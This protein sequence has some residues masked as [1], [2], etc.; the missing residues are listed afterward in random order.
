MLIFGFLIKVIVMNMFRGFLSFIVVSFAL[1]LSGCASVV[2]GNSPVTYESVDSY[3]G[4]DVD[5]VCRALRR[6]YNIDS[7]YDR[8]NRFYGS[9]GFG[10]PYNYYKRRGLSF[11][12]DYFWQ[13]RN[14]YNKTE[15]YVRNYLRRYSIYSKNRDYA[16]LKYCYNIYNR[17]YGR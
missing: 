2:N 8:R 5:E 10:Y 3:F 4:A 6:S 11:N 13:N 17:S 9:Y 16:K 12:Y 7:L 1:C 14:A 15:Y